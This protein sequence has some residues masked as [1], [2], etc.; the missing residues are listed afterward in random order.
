MVDAETKLKT[1]LEMVMEDL[2]AEVQKPDVKVS[3]KTRPG[4]EAHFST[5]LPYNMLTTWQGACKDKKRPGQLDA[6]K[7][8][9]IILRNQST[10]LYRNGELI[11]V[12]GEAMT[13]KSQFIMDAVGAT[14]P[15]ETTVKFFGQDGLVE[16][17]AT[18]ILSA[19]GYDEE[20][21]ADPTNAS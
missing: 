12:N 6:L 14:S 9:C 13:L 11:E 7:L 16:A 20:V 18:A 5:D 8:A 1:M 21:V 17:T 19:C 2:A 4:W 3:V 15:Q 10:A